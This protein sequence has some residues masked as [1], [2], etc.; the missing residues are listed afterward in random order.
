[1]SEKPRVVIDTQ[2]FL[3]AAINRKSLPAKLVFDLKDEYQLLVSSGIWA[4]VQDV[5]NR[6][7]LRTKFP[8]LTDDVADAVLIVLSGAEQVYPLEV[9]HVSR[10]PKDDIFLATALAGGAAYIV[11]E[12]KDLLTLN[13]YEGIQIIDALGFWH[14][15]QPPSA[16]DEV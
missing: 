8:S 4:E 6:P 5:L 3:R 9:P 12:D 2:L 14:L 15:L 11:S 16:E 1:V 10:D 7:S 13:P